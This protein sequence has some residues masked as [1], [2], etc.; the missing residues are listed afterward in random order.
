[1]K[2]ITKQV[3]ERGAAALAVSAP[4]LYHAIYQYRMHRSGAEEVNRELMEYQ[5]A[6]GGFG[7][8]I[9]ADFQLPSSTPMAVSTAYGI[10]REL[11]TAADRQMVGAAVNYLEQTYCAPRGGWYSVTSE[12]NDYPH[13]P[14]WEYDAKRGGTVIDA[15]WGN[16]TAEIC[17]LLHE[18][19]DMVK[20]LDVDMLID[21]AIRYL[22]GLDTYR[23]PHEIYCF[24]RLYDVL[25]AQRQHLMHSSLYRAI[26]ESMER[27]RSLWGSYHPRPCDFVSDPQH[28][29]YGALEGL[30]EAHLDHLID[31][32]TPEGL[33]IPHWEWGQDPQSW[34]YAKR[35]WTAVLF[36][37]HSALLQ[38]HG[39]IR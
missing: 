31:T 29:L 23:S 30:A 4:P 19:R 15:H 10:W 37:K 2:T 38:A 22:R 24:I 18:H 17:A 25:D 13:A 12:V 34:A 5:N 3:I 9:E 39:R 11:G 14:W 33:W 20:E 32:V 8:S 26:G 35:A 16:P 6:D 27:D 21:R 1:M 36:L 7:H 28:P